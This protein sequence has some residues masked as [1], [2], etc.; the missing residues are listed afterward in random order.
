MFRK[1]EGTF[2]SEADGL[3]ISVL[4]VLPDKEPKGIMQLVHGM[5]EHKERYLPFMEYLAGEGYVTVIHDHRGHGKSV[6]SIADLGYM[7][8]GG[9]E[10]MLKDIGTVNRTVREKYPE[11][12]LILMGHSMGSLAVRAYARQ[13]DDTIDMLIV[14]G[15][16]SKNAA[17]PLGEMIARAEQK[18]RGARHR[19]RILEDLSFGSYVLRFRD[20]KDRNAWIC[21]DE[22]VYKAYGESKFCGFTFTDD[23]YLALFRLMKEAYDVKN[24]RCTNQKLPVLF[25][26]GAEDPCLGNVRQFAK[27]VQDMRRAGYLDVKGKLYPGMRHEILN[28]KEKEKVYHDLTVYIKKKGF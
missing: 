2:S 28:E 21:S 27:A 16:P 14:C 15:S 22:E 12:P 23:A 5:S 4:A 25:V 10:A 7:Y 26:S 18:L 17:R 11:L 9:A 8:G 20:E 1:Y 24:W 19:S 3:E 6:K 13:H